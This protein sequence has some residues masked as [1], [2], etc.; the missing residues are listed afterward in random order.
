MNTKVDTACIAQ[1]V[2]V[3]EN[4]GLIA[5]PT[6]GVFG[7]GCDPQNETALARVIAI[8]Q[9]DAAKGLILVADQLEQLTA[10]V[11]PFTA[12]EYKRIAPTWPGPVTWVVRAKPDVSS[13]L[14]GGRHTLAV[15][16]SDHP[17]VQSLCR[18]FGG[19]I[20]STSANLS[21]Q[22]A[23]LSAAQTKVQLGEKIELVIDA[24][25][26]EHQGA[27]TIRDAATGERLR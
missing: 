8:K 16:I 23:C 12:E 27:S 13:L 22:P 5:Y 21:G 1:A 19:A 20:V 18:S 26:G 25:T 3:L 4:G 14:T 6:E 9:R 24:A 2:K 15:R 17:V 7:I 11:Q 10:F